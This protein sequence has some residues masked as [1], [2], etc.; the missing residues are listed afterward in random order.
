M[1]AHYTEITSILHYFT[2][3]LSFEG[4]LTHQNV[5]TPKHVN[6]LTHAYSR[7]T[8]ID[9]NIHRQARTLKSRCALIHVPSNPAH[10][11]SLSGQ[12][13][14]MLE[15]KREKRERARQIDRK[16]EREMLPL[17]IKL[18]SSIFRQW[19]RDGEAWRGGRRDVNSECSMFLKRE[20][21]I[22]SGRWLAGEGVEGKE[23]RERGGGKHEGCENKRCRDFVNT[24]IFHWYDWFL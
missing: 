16:S 5:H 9:I 12:P 21:C 6:T 3:I 8:C 1:S 10:H 24:S 4:I 19:R 18:R 2:H 7:L 11:A 15:G 17:Q 23:N 13:L 20:I 14:M 22:N